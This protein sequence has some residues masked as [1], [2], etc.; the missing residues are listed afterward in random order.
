[1]RDE[2]VLIA[3]S[4][5]GDKDAREVLIEKNLGLVRHIVRRFT[6]RGV[7]PD[8]LFQIGSIGLIKAIDKFDLSLGLQFS[9]YA[10]PLI[11]GEIRRFL[12]DDGIVKISR[13]VKENSARL[14]KVREKLL[15]ELGREPYLEELIRA[16]GMTRE[17][18][19]LALEADN[20][21]ES[22]EGSQESQDGTMLSLGDRISVNTEAGSA[23]ASLYPGA[24][25]PEKE[26]LLDRLLLR[27]L[28]EE[29]EPEDKKLIWLRYFRDKSQVEIAQSMG[30]SQVQVSRREKKILQYLREK[31]IS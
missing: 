26:R 5:S 15:G 4:Q 20:C 27:Q 21:V 3:R 28:M 14:S 24:G 10:V 25:D 2:S 6:G 31:A 9:T 12:R 11:M 16:S 22:L 30:I 23:C 7:E 13:T 8:D 17:E 19:I 18:V 29:L 1:M